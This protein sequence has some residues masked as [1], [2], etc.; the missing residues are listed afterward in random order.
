MAIPESIEMFQYVYFP[1]DFTI[2]VD[3][4]TLIYRDGSITYM[5]IINDYVKRRISIITAGLEATTEELTKIYKN[6]NTVQVKL[7]LIEKRKNFNTKEILSTRE[8]INKTF[9]LIPMKDE[10]S[11]I[12]STDSTSTELIDE[13]RHLQHFEF[14]LIPMEAINILEMERSYI[15]NKVTP[16]EILQAAFVQRDIPAG[17]VIATPPQQSEIIE[18]VA[19]PLGTL[20][21]NI[22]HINNTYGLYAGEPIIYYDLKYYYCICKENPDIIIDN[23]TDYGNVTFILKDPSSPMHEI[24]GSNDDEENHIHWVNLSK[25]PEVIATRARDTSVSVSTVMTVDANGTVDK[26][27]LDE[28]STKVKYVYATNPLM[29]DRVLNEMIYGARV[30]IT[31]K[32][33]SVM[34]LTPYKD[35][36][37][38]VDPSYDNLNLTDNVF[39]I[40][41]WSLNITRESGDEYISIIEMDL[42]QVERGQVE[43]TVE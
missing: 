19:V 13:Q 31:T 18:N 36:T 23:A 28:S 5:N 7:T 12:Y 25:E 10:S 34:M 2:T 37:F 38:M 6:K 41:Y 22:R 24:N 29:K 30:H 32:D 26:K 21:S 17:T 3:G 9:S 35:Y 15:L 27:T 43:M 8:F 42:Y 1:K 14:Y 4:E 11:F 20:I 33:M 40:L 39:R 16:A